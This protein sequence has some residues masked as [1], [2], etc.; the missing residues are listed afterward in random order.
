MIRDESHFVWNERYRPQVVSDCILPLATKK[1]AEGIVEQ[2][3]CPTL[4]F[5][6]SAGT[7]K[8]TLA[9]CIA[10]ELNADFMIINAS[11]ETGIA[12]IRTK[13]LQFASTVSFTDSKKITLL[14]EADG[15][16]GDAQASLRAFT[17][18]F[19]GNHSFI[20]TCNFKN[21]L[22]EPLLSR[23]QIIDFRI[24]GSEKS[25]LAMQFFKRVTQILD[26]EGI[27]YDK[28]VVAEVVN[29]HFP[30]FRRCLNELQRYSVGGIIDS[31]ILAE[32][33]GDSFNELIQT[34]KDKKFSAMRKWVAQNNDLE[35]SSLFRMFY[36]SAIEK[37]EPKSIPA[38]VMLLS[39]YQF[40]ES[41]V[42]DKE[43]NR[44]A[45]LTEIL[46]SGDFQWK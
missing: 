18:E 32:F 16:S 3:K 17:E 41:F 13:V 20:F 4:L 28:K 1:L 9:N 23:C 5:T 24:P 35:S 43:I 46:V 26:L 15:L 21:K 31:G 39:D 29:H 19:A 38:L 36:D 2:G 8:T 45:F 7:G 22:I 11:L 10:N 34:L 12:N 44:A 6:G 37:L 30:D 42:A 25:K 27:V 14:D 33:N 40:K